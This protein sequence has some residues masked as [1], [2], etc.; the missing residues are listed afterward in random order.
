MTDPMF[1]GYTIFC[2]D[3]RDEIGGKTT[4]VGV[5]KGV[6]LVHD[7][8]PII[9]PKFGLAIRYQEK[10]GA[11]SEQ[12]NLK[13]FVPG[14]EGD[15]AVVE[16]VLP[17][18]D[19][20]QMPPPPITD[21]DAEPSYIEVASNIIFTPLVFPRPGLIKVRAFCGEEV[22]RLGSLQILKAPTPNVTTSPPS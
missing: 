17:M 16:G 4:F 8:F 11:C 13:V 6:M 21:A 12:I 15:V 1:R 22:I 5:Y 20:R 3:I 9:I 7:D 2:D 18:D 10:L 19:V 14:N